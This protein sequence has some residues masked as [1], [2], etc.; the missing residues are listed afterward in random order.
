MWDIDMENRKL[1]QNKM[2]LKKELLEFL[3]AN[4]DFGLEEP[5]KVVDIYIAVYKEGKSDGYFINLK[6]E[7]CSC[8]NGIIECPGCDGE[9]SKFGTC[10]GCNGKGKVTCGKCGGKNKS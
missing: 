4:N 10:A 3:E 6:S 9:Q 8:D 1:N 2:D 7:S 5:E